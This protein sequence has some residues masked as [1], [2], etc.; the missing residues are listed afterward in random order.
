M[1][2]ASTV[3]LVAVGLTVALVALLLV[4]LRWERRGLSLKHRVRTPVP[5]TVGLTWSVFQAVFLFYPILVVVLPDVAYGTV[6]HFGFPFDTAVQVVGILLWGAGAGLLL[7]CSRLLGPIMMTDGVVED[8]E[9]VTQGPY[10]VIRHPTYVGHMLVAFGV[11]TIFLSYPLLGLALLTVAF[12][13]VTAGGEERLLASQEGFGEV[14][15]D[16]MEETGRFL[17]RLGSRRRST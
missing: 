15:R 4:T 10:A 5:R 3:R 17:P 11:E 1:L 12:A 9:L 14:Y 16:Y 2:D 8:H 6:L 7:W 13:H